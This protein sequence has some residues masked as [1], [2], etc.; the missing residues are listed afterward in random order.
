MFSFFSFFASRSG[1]HF[2]GPL[3]PTRILG[4]AIHI[5]GLFRLHSHKN[6][7]RAYLQFE[8][9][10]SSLWKWKRASFILVLIVNISHLLFIAWAFSQS[11]FK[12]RNHGDLSGF[13]SSFT[14]L[15]LNK[16]KIQKLLHINIV[17]GNEINAAI[18]MHNFDVICN[19]VSLRQQLWVDPKVC[20]LVG[21]RQRGRHSFYIVTSS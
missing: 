12:W 14:R 9:I 17:N 10:V 13:R 2:L 21:R 11:I 6:P 16:E 8:H 15:S 20:Y 18:S 4:N 19:A 7:S 5:S 3:E 1:C